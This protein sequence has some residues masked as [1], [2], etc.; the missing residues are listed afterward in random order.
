MKADTVW[1]SQ[2]VQLCLYAEARDGDASASPLCAKAKKAASFVTKRK[3][4][5]AVMKP[6][7]TDEKKAKVQIED[8]TDKERLLRRSQRKRQRSMG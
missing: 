1:T 3:R 8:A 4:N 2:R 6:L 5:N 7:S